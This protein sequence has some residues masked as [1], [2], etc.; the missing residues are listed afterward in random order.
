[1]PPYAVTALQESSDWSAS[2]SSILNA[3]S[4][5]GRMLVGLLADVI[6]PLNALF[7]SLAVSNFAILAIWL[8]FKSLGAFIAA[9]LIF[10]FASG[11]VVS[12]V[13]VVTANLFGVKRLASI[14]GLLFFSYTLGTLVCSPVGGALLD[15]YGHGTNYTPLIIYDGSFFSAATLLLGALRLAVSRSLV[16]SI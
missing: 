2:I 1:M 6:G 5:A 8:P 10:G 3:G 12:L 13:P 7:I 14:L 15:K 16:A 9:A 11:S 4:I